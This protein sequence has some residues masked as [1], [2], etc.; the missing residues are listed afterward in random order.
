MKKHSKKE[1]TNL[2]ELDY[3]TQQDFDLKSDYES[4]FKSFIQLIYKICLQLE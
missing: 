4:I 3:M 1:E 2:E